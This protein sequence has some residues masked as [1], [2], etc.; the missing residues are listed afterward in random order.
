MK[1]ANEP[2][3]YCPLIKKDCIGWKCAFYTQIRG[4]NP[5]TG[6]PMDHEGC[7]IAFLPALFIENSQVQRETG[8]AVESTRNE[9]VNRM[10]TANNLQKTFIDMVKD[11]SARRMPENTH[12]IT[13]D[14]N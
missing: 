1:K 13:D 3:N 8:A 6:E 7:T 2:G 4:T 9:M 12:K 14:R 11:A 5:N 10:D